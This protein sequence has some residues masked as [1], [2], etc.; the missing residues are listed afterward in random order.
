MMD[1]VVPGGVAADIAPG[2]AEAIGSAL[3]GLAAELPDLRLLPEAGE[4]VT[5]AGNAQGRALERLRQIADC[6]GVVHNLLRDMPEEAV[7]VPLPVESG[8][9]IGH[10]IGPG[11]EIWHWLR[12]DHGQIASGF[13]CD[14]G[15][16]RWPEL[17]ATMEG[18]QLDDL[19]L[20]L[21]SFGL[22]SS[23]VD[24]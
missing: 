18:G 11:G 8:E 20:I 1:C 6:I 24:L 5:R 7:S 2:G 15:W 14:P 3:N 4:L 23:G 22:T 12:L 21:A 17:E 9:G 13:M 10:A 16:A 19:R